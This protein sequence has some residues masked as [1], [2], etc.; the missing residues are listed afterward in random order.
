MF[1]CG[2]VKFGVGKTDIFIKYEQD[3]KLECKPSWHR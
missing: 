1:Y 3:R 2:I